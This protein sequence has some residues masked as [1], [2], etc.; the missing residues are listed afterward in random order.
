MVPAA[1]TAIEIA[2]PVRTHIHTHTHIYS[3]ILTH[4]HTRR[5]RGACRRGVLRKRMSTK[6]ARSLFN[7]MSLKGRRVALNDRQIDGRVRVE[8]RHKNARDRSNRSAR[9]Y[10]LET[11][12]RDV[13]CA[14][15]GNR[16]SVHRQLEHGPSSTHITRRS[17]R[18]N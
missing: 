8:P 12:D 9:R 16:L 14:H 10:W 17:Q 13:S 3:H 7:G 5:G 1:H 11:N 15:G 2:A 6:I 18:V 4:S